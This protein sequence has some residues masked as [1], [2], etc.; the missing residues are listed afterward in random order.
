VTLQPCKLCGREATLRDSHVIPQFVYRWLKAT[1]VGGMRRNEQPNRRVQ[2]G[3]KHPW[4]CDGCEQRFSDWEQPF[5]EQ[6]FIRAHD[7][8]VGNGSPV[9]SYEQWALKF[10]TSI[11][12]RALLYLQSKDGMSELNEAERKACD[13]AERIWREF[14]LSNR[15]HPGSCEQHILMTGL[16]EAA[17]PIGL[18]PNLNRYLT[19]SVGIDLIRS[20]VDILTHVKLGEIII[21]GFIKN[22][23]PRWK[24]T[25]IHLRRG[26]IG[27]DSI[28]IP[29]QMLD[30]W[31]AKANE[32]RALASELSTKQKQKI[33]QVLIDNPEAA[34]NSAAFDALEADIELSGSRAFDEENLDGSTVDV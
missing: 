9:I 27:A 24:G 12:W 32:M 25:K 18:S 29:E 22:D 28:V 19:R 13:N 7:I 8:D 5:S 2:D 17:P 34:A 1:S 16:L 15:P 4:L 14:L 23:G 20:S 3:P 31:N 30:Y 6:I 33:H 11:S 26:V 10:A 21:L